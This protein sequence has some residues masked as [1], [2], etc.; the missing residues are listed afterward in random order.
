MT[1]LFEGGQLVTGDTNAEAFLCH[2]VMMDTYLPNINLSS[3][4]FS[5]F[6]EITPLHNMI[7]V[8]CMLDIS[9][10]SPRDKRVIFQNLV[11]A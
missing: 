2:D 4:R 5:N 10:E 11:V 1:G 3:A 7:S 6:F 9:A 8:S